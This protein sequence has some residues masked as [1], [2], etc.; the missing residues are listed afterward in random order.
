V[1][2][3]DAIATRLARLPS[4]VVRPSSTLA[5]A[6]LPADPLE[7]ARKLLVSH[8]L[9]GSFMRSG[10]GFTLNWQLLER[11]AGAVRTGGTISVPN[12]DLV[13]LQNE[14]SEQVFASLRGTGHLDPA[15]APER[16]SSGDG[17][18]RRNTWKRVPC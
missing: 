2:L 13:A 15:N 17:K 8:L 12:L 6:N 4:L 5:P 11:D 14:I 18:C 3:G 9:R 16:K 10:K 1:A 7:A